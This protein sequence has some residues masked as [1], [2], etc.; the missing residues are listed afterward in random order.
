MLGGYET[1]SRKLVIRTFYFRLHVAQT[2][3]DISGFICDGISQSHDEARQFY[4]FLTF[5]SFWG[6]F[7]H[8]LGSFATNKGSF[9]WLL[10]CWL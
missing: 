9:L 3:L 4:Y 6:K 7:Y 1:A 10:V 8:L 5:L 2:S